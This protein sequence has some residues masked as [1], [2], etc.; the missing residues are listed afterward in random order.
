MM[1]TIIMMMNETCYNWMFSLNQLVNL[2]AH[3]NIST[4][5]IRH[6]L[7]LLWF[8]TH[9]YSRCLVRIAC[10]MLEPHGSFYDS[11]M[12]LKKLVSII[13]ITLRIAQTKAKGMQIVMASH[14]Q[15]FQMLMLSYQCLFCFANSIQVWFL[16]KVQLAILKQNQWRK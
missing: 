9:C 3:G 12:S 15:L 6:D 7:W 13:L 5:V 10:I 2:Q 8:T 14:G 16:L 1:M 11:I 4:S